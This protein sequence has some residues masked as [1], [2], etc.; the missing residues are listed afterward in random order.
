M[1]LDAL[2]PGVFSPATRS[3]LRSSSDPTTPEKCTAVR[4]NDVE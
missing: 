4:D 3:A 1:I 2:D